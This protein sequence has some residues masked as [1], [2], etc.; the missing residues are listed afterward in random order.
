MLRERFGDKPVHHGAINLFLL[1][2]FPPFLDKD[3]WNRQ[4][5]ID[6][7]VV[8]LIKAKMLVYDRKA[9]GSVVQEWK[10]K[11]KDKEPIWLMHY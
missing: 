2:H 5:M 10:E 4:N 11:D 7:L 9:G 3:M 6:N 8:R 1:A